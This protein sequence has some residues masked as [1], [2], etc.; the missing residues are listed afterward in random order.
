MAQYNFAYVLQRVGE[1]FPRTDSVLQAMI[2]NDIFK[3]FIR[4]ICSQ[5]P[6]WFLKVVPG[7]TF[8]AS[9][10]LANE[11]A[12]TSYTKVTGAWLDRGWLH[13]QPGVA[14]Y[15]FSAPAEFGES[16][17]DDAS[18]W[19]DVQIQ[20]LDYVKEFNLRGSFIRDLECKPG[21]G[22]FTQTDWSSR[23]QPAIAL[24]ETG[25][26]DSGNRISW[27]RF[28]PTP[29][30][31]AIYAVGFTLRV[32]INYDPD[33]PSTGNTTNRM[34]EEYPEVFIHAGMLQAAE[35]F[36]EARNIEYYSKKLWGIPNDGGKGKTKQAEGS[37][38]KMKRDTERWHRQNNDSIPIFL[39]A[40]G[41]V[42]RENAHPA[43]FHRRPG[44]YYT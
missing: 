25:V 24:W 34:L 15:V 5:Y 11:A 26:D 17:D 1:R 3:N 19:S 29:Q 16:F 36:N 35:Y 12:L 6:Y 20:Q 10:P 39:G 40:R 14:R 32:P 13:V 2:T 30:N 38:A 27:L 41:A 18:F 23:G 28:N 9:F 42:G 22:H 8:P 44:I 43:S 33:S 21:S 31:H 7:H 4:E 37:M